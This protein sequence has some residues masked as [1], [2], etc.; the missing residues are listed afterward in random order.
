[1][2]LELELNISGTTND[3]VCVNG[4]L[5]SSGSYSSSELSKYYVTLHDSTQS[6]S[7]FGLVFV[8]SEFINLAARSN[9][10]GHVLSLTQAYKDNEFLLLASQLTCTELNQ[11]IPSNHQ[12][13][14]PLAR[15]S[16]A[17]SCNGIVD[18]RYKDVDLTGVEDTELN[19]FE[20]VLERT[21]SQGIPR[22]IV[23]RR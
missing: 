17:T 13:Y 10:V 14:F 19:N 20:L 3:E 7:S 11:T 9:G 21:E 8:G 23:R 4:S 6:N 5:V 15:L 12:V 18:L 1:M 22:V 16:N 2:T